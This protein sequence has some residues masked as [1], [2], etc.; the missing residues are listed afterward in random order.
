MPQEGLTQNGGSAAR[1]PRVH[2]ARACPL[3]GEHGLHDAR[4]GLASG[5]PGTLRRILPLVAL[6]VAAALPLPT[7][8]AS[9]TPFGPA[10]DGLAFEP[11]LGQLAAGVAY[12]ARA[13]G[14]FLLVADDGAL[15]AVDPAGARV[16][17]R[18][19]GARVSRIDALEP[20][21][22]VHHYLLGDDPSAWVANVPRYG[23][24][25][26]RDA[27]PGIDVAVRGGA[28]GEPEY[29]LLVA[30]GADLSRARVAFRGAEA[31]LATDGSLTAGFLT[32]R[33][34]VAWHE[35]AGAREVL[36]ARFVRLAE[37]F[38]VEVDGRD[39][40][41]PLVV[42][43]VLSSS[44]YLGGAGDDAA[45]AVAVAP[46]GGARVVGS[47]TSASF[48]TLAALQ[49]ARGGGRDAFV[50]AFAPDGSLLYST[51]L[52]GAADD[53]AED[54]ALDADGTLLLA[55]ST[56]SS[57]FPTASPFQAANR[58]RSDA[59]A[60]RLAPDGSALAWSTYLGGSAAGSPSWGN[61]FAY[62]VAAGP[63]GEVCLGGRTESTDFPT[64]A[65]AQ[66][67][68]AGTPADAFVACFAAGGGMLAFS[69][70]LGGTAIDAAHAV[71]V[72]AAGTV[73]AAGMTGSVN[74][75]T[76]AAFDATFNG[77][78]DGFL[79]RYSA[80]GALLSS[81]YLGGAKDDIAWD[82]ALDPL[83]APH[84]AGRTWSVDFPVL[85][86]TQPFS[87]HQAVPG[88]EPHEHN[89]AD[90]FVLRFAP[91]AG[92]LSWSTW[93]GG[94][95]WEEAL[96]LSVDANGVATVAGRTESFDFPV[97]EPLQATKADPGLFV[98][99]AFV[100]RYAPDGRSVAFATYVGGA[101]GGTLGNAVGADATGRIWLAGQTS[102]TAFPA[103]A[104]HDAS[105]NGGQDAV[106]ASLVPGTPTAPAAPTGLQAATGPGRGQIALRWDPPADDGGAILTRYDVYAGSTS[107]ALARIGE[108]TRAAYVE[109]GLADGAV[110][111]YA[112]VAVTGAGA[113]PASAEAS[114]ASF[115]RPG[116]ARDVVAEPGPDLASISLAWQAPADGGTP[117]SY[118]IYR[119]LASGGETTLVAEVPGSRHSHVDAPPLPALT[120][121]Y[122]V[123]AANPAG[124]GPRSASASAQALALPLP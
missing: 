41:R 33:A 88:G 57:D 92:A 114:G 43:P 71:A 42:D 48:P 91:D 86:P 107:G 89:K 96:A 62:G 10:G 31:A 81:T 124:E 22:G 11:N 7:P 120:Y 112:V 18:F 59:F 27:W 100:A 23:R 113:G 40:R 9:A 28:G 55:G 61:D 24:L 103:R 47:T 46:D 21:P 17:V 39:P 95:G 75:P 90:G 16:E 65:A 35:T 6:L 64:A 80:S 106:V 56:T 2:L 25:V 52:G 45:L 109:S 94:E 77:I 110:R 37:G 44:T 101:G 63:T 53:V 26:L 76:P 102:S 93:I 108:A 4:G 14:F 12:A 82:L 15:V 79:A 105:A 74:F 104:A 123:A 84:V 66:P 118:R 20:Q 58:G 85:D 115:S 1:G 98:F 73:F 34:P 29:D 97:V 99:D 67:A 69:T 117:T 68:R 60:A 51:F 119:G 121:W 78:N 38:G 30:P 36:P 3:R 116:A 54:V 83:G 19:V 5:R 50:A 111:F 122:K 8:A 70:Y 13:P 32:Q 72:D 87:N 49:P